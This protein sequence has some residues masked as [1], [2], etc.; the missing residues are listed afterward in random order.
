MNFHEPLLIASTE[1]DYESICLYNW[2]VQWFQMLTCNSRWMKLVGVIGLRMY[3]SGGRHG[4]IGIGE[5]GVDSLQEDALFWTSLPVAIQHSLFL[6][7]LS[8]FFKRTVILKSAVEWP[9][10]PGRLKCPPI[11]FFN[12]VVSDVRLTLIHSLSKGLVFVQ[13]R[14][15]KGTDDMW[16]HKSH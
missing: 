3:G 13:C 8:L 9:K 4:E 12:T 10:W 1:L 7:S 5:L 2:R 14:G 11:F 16:W 6:I 15:W